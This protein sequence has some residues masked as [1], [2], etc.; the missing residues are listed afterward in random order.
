PRERD[1]AMPLNIVSAQ[2]LET[3]PE[4][5]AG[6][7]N[8]FIAASL[9]DVT[10]ALAAQAA[11]PRVAALTVDLVGHST[12]DHH[13]LRLGATVIDALDRRVLR[14]FEG[15]AGSGVLRE[16]NAVALRL[17]GCQTAMSPSGQRTMRLLAAVL[18]IP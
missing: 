1:A 12:R 2:A 15:V 13:L 18:R 6:A 4:A 16:V 10:R 8:T 11:R 3:I 17:L 9:G 14:F 5:M 7:S